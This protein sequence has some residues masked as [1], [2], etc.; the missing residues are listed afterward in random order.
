MS[1]VRAHV[2]TTCAYGNAQNKVFLVT[3]VWF[4]LCFYID[5]SAGKGQLC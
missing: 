3:L 5:V 1:A 4:Y 2:E